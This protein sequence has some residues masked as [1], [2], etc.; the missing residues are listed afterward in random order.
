MPATTEATIELYRHPAST[1]SRT[2][3]MCAA[4][5]APDIEMRAFD[6]FSGEHVMP[7]WLAI[8]PGHTVPGLAEWQ[9]GKTAGQVI[10]SGGAQA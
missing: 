2:V 4:E 5:D 3:M 7:E 6:V 9:A 10:G 1:T 8:D